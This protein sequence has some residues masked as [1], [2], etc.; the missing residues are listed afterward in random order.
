MVRVNLISPNK[1]ADQHLIAEYN[2]LL[3]LLGYVKKYP[4]LVG[5]PGDYCLG[6]GHILFF[7]DKLIY[8][9]KRHEQL[10]IEMKKRGFETRKTIN[11]SKFKKE[12][13]RDWKPSQK[14]LNIIKERLIWKINK[15]PH[16]Y[17]YYGEKKTREFFINLINLKKI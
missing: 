6:K 13:I 4:N 9:R 1:L 2:E 5:I 16:F 15:K 8:I 7:K 10:K 11:I 14:D 12:L 3:M 17:R